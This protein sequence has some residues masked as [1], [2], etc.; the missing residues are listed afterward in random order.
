[1]ATLQSN[2]RA[3]VMHRQRLAITHYRVLYGRCAPADD[4]DLSMEMKSK[5]RCTLFLHHYV[6]KM[7][8]RLVS[9]SWSL[10]QEFK[11]TNKIMV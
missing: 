7:Y 3:L 5:L 2:L 6:V 11:Y 4:W 9:F 10:C 8:S 1:M